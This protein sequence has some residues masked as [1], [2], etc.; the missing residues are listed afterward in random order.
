MR[1][2]FDV[3]VVGGRC[4]GAP[5][6]MLLARAGLRV[7]VVDRARFPSE[8]PSTHAI[9]ASGVTILERLGL[10]ERVE[11]QAGVVD[12]G[13]VNLDGARAEVDSVTRMAGAPVLNAR[14][15]TLAAILLE[16]AAGAGADVRT[17]TTVTGVVEERGQV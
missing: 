12:A 8:T 2:R 10:R 16:A 13:I 11:P 15:E 5:L 17:Q 7:C 3:V 1:E 4:A 14:R 9:H 6:A